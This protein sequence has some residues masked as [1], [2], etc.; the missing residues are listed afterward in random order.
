MEIIN[1][2]HEAAW[3]AAH[4]VALHVL[5]GSLLHHD[6]PWSPDV[7]DYLE[8]TMPPLA[9]RL[10]LTLPWSR[11]SPVNPEKDHV[12]LLDNTAFRPA[13]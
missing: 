10:P 2:V 8:A 3:E 6:A 1:N 13:R 5:D 11:I 9:G 12:W 7:P 4:N